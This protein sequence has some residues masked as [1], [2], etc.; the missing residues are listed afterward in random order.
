METTGTTPR[1]YP[2]G[3]LYGP[4]DVFW[5]AWSAAAGASP[6]CRSVYFE[7][8]CTTQWAGG[9]GGAAWIAR[10]D[11]TNG[12]GSSTMRWTVPPSSPTARGRRRLLPTP[13]AGLARLPAGH[14]TAAA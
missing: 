7:G 11:S 4:Q 3:H 14:Y 10:T 13:R 12:A 1:R 5:R 9:G 2:N 6:P 8:L